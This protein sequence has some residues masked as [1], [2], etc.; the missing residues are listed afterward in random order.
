M[1]QCLN[2]H[3]YMH[4]MMRFMH[5]ILGTKTQKQHKEEFFIRSTCISTI[6]VAENYERLRVEAGA[7]SFVPQYAAKPKTVLKEIQNQLGRDC[8]ELVEEIEALRQD[9][10]YDE[11]ID[12]YSAHAKTIYSSH[13]YLDL[14]NAIYHRNTVRIIDGTE[15]ELK[16]ATKELKGG[17]DDITYDIPKGDQ[18]AVHDGDVMS[19]AH[20]YAYMVQVAEYR[21]EKLSMARYEG[22]QQRTAIE[23]ICKHIRSQRGIEVFYNRS[24][25]EGEE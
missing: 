13:I 4:R 10:V 12:G 22:I 24:E 14:V 7:L 21:N 17:T 6:L 11:R 9:M 16:V 8:R 25:D 1:S 3:G 23:E 20:F 18:Y 15:V 19:L 2:H 5:I